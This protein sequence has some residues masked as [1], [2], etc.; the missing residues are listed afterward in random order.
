M[1]TLLAI[2]LVFVGCCT[3]VVFLELLVRSV[4]INVIKCIYYQP[5]HAYTSYNYAIFQCLKSDAVSIC[6]V[7]VSLLVR[8]QGQIVQ[9]FK[10]QSCNNTLFHNCNMLCVA[11]GTPQFT[12]LCYSHRD[13]PGCGN[14]VT[15]AQ[16][17]FIA[18]EG[19]I[20]ESNFGRKK[21][22]IPMRY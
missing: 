12:L 2:L 3:N 13:F 15:F 11:C 7:L 10:V 14:I 21:S 4:W 5:Y 17:A 16:F 18:L 22:T 19:F 1:G 8:G 20:F 6:I 9:C